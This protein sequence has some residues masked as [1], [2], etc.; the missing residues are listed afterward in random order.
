MSAPKACK[1]Q[2]KN[3]GVQS[4][5]NFIS[6]VFQQVYPDESISNEGTLIRCAILSA[7]FEYVATEA[8]KLAKYSKKKEYL[9]ER[10]LKIAFHLIL[11][12]ELTKYAITEDKYHL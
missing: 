2:P 7:I 12:G 5:S 8:K 10:E 3:T 11:P 9:T 1:L 4:Y 6:N